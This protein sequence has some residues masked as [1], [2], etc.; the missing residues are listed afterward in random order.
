MTDFHW[1]IV[2]GAASVVLGYYGRE[3]YGRLFKKRPW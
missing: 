3:L 1:G 2:V